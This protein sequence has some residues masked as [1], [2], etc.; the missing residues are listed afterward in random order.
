MITRAVCRVLVGR[1]DE[2]STLEDALLAAC[3]GEGSVVVLS[4]DAGMGKSRLCRELADR[5]EKIGAT[6]L[7]GSC[8]EADLALPYLPFLEAIRN[9]LASGESPRLPERPAGHTRELGK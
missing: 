5:A 8:S 4:G 3:R 2:L 7:E 1:E 9:H 6:V